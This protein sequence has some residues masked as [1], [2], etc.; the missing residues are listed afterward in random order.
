MLVPRPLALI[1]WSIPASSAVSTSSSKTFGESVEPRPIAGPEP[2][3]WL[4]IS[5]SSTPGASVAW[6]TST[7]T[8]RSG[9]T[10]K[11]EVRAP[12]R[13]ISSCTA[14]TAAKLPASEAAL[15]AAAQ[16][17]Q[18]DVGA[19]PVVHR[20]GDQPLAGEAHRL[21]GDD[22]RVADPDQL[23]RLVA[24]GGADVDVEAFQLDDLL[25]LVGVEQVDRLAPDNARHQA[26]P[27]PHLD[28]LPDQDLRI[29][30]ADRSEPEEALLVDVGDDEADLVDV[31]DHGEQGSVLAEAGDRGAE[32]VGGER[33]ERG[34]LTPDR[35]SRPLVAR[36]ERAV[37]SSLSRRAGISRPS[38]GGELFD[39][40]GAA[41][42]WRPRRSC[43]S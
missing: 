37:R 32:P 26:V 21:G 29:P 39:G 35:C 41:H 43:V 31:A 16:R 20:A 10:S 36:R 2:S 5:F 27:S 24:V 15:M 23:S 28:P 13:P 6:V 17:L 22:D 38:E 42:R 34:F 40:S 1:V 18:G 4:P 12:N 14:A 30:T 33:G 8:A 19:E 7:A 9:R 25:A 11:A 3:G